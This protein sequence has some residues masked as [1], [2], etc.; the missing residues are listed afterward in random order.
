MKINYLRDVYRREPFGCWQKVRGKVSGTIQLS[1]ESRGPSAFRAFKCESLPLG[2]RCF[3]SV[4][5][6]VRISFVRAAPA[7]SRQMWLIGD[8]VH[9]NPLP[10]F[11][12]MIERG[13]VLLKHRVSPRRGQGRVCPRA[14]EKGKFIFTQPI[15]RS[16]PG[17]FVQ[18]LIQ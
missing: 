6:F 2:D 9:L 16:S 5:C 4:T 15:R 10:W 1:F 11:L 8:R 3:K 7:Y 17:L 12:E 18:G 14:P 13:R